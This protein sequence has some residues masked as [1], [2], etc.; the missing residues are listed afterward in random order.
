[1]VKQDTKNQTI[2][3]PICESIYDR[4]MSEPAFAR[5]LIDELYVTLPELFQK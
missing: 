3:L 4:F 1:M 2:T 5:K